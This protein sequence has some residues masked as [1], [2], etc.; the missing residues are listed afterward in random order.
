MAPVQFNWVSCRARNDR[1]S[2]AVSIAHEASAI[3]RREPRFPSLVRF[4]RSKALQ[5]RGVRIPCGSRDRVD[6]S[7]DREFRAVRIARSAARGLVPSLRLRAA[8]NRLRP[9]PARR[10]KP[11]LA[12]VY[13]GASAL[14]WRRCEQAR[15][16]SASLL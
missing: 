10:A 3:L 15:Y 4:L 12:G 9:G 11:D 2:G 16:K 7:L 6:R 13:A 1:V 8:S 5:Y 14:H